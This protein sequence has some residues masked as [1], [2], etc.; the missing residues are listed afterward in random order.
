[1]LCMPTANDV[2]R[3][4]ED[5][6]YL[7]E[8]SILESLPEYR[9]DLFTLEPRKRVI[10]DGVTHEFDLWIKADRPHG[11]ESIFVFECKNRRAPVTKNDILVFSAK[12]RAVQATRGFIVST[13]FS[14]D[15]RAQA[16]KDE[17]LTLVT[18]ETV[19]AANP[20]WLAARFYVPQ[21][22]DTYL[23]I[24]SHTGEYVSD[25][26][27]EGFDRAHIVVAGKNIPFREYMQG[28]LAELLNAQNTRLLTAGLSAGLYSWTFIEERKFKPGKFVL[29]DRQISRLELVVKGST[30]IVEPMLQ[31]RFDV[32]T[33]GRA[34]VLV[35]VEYPN[36]MKITL[37][38]VTTKNL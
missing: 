29:G 18:V 30:A 10:V 17:R 22:F 3:M 38:W 15:A 34:H 14:R 1:M 4:L 20:S 8:K 26:P 25:W 12:L 16:V 21:T 27:Q 33:R 32:A 28:W 11:Y 24:K 9:E 37:Q 35:P 2:G 5:A 7:I 13:A 6:V 31:V 36:G 23:E 19:S